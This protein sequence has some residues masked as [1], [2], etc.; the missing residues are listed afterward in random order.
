MYT[1]CILVTPLLFCV[2][3]VQLQ[4]AYASPSSLYPALDLPLSNVVRNVYDKRDGHHHNHNHHAAPLLELNETEVTLY[5]APTPP[6][7][8]TIDWEDEGYEKR[9]GSL[10]IV[11]GLFMCLAFFVALPMG[12]LIF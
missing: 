4:C 1:R 3:L 12:S 10:M 2:A 5:H 6:S 9:H 7:Y 8:Y 11:H